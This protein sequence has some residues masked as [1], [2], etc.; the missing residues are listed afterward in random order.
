[1]GGGDK[2]RKAPSPCYIN[3]PLRLG[4]EQRR[5]LGSL[6]LISPRLP[7]ASNAASQPKR[8]PPGLS[9]EG[10]HFDLDPTVQTKPMSK[11]QE[12]TKCT[13]CIEAGSG[14]W[15]EPKG[16]RDSDALRRSAKQPRRSTRKSRPTTAGRTTRHIF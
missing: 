8:Y 14:S 2:A 4:T 15:C 12:E 11:W 13:V 5:T 6:P 7:R 16:G 10:V 9:K 3:H 1:M